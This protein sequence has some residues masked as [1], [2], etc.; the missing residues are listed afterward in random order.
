V[1]PESKFWKL[2]KEN[3]KDIH[4]TRFENWA[5]QGVPDCYGI[6]DGVSIWVELKV[7]TSNRIK[8]SPFQIAWNFSHSLKG[9]RNF[10]MA[11]TPSPSLLYIFPGS[12]VRSIGSIAKLP[13]PHW[14]INMVQG[15]QPWQQVQRILLHSP[16]PP[17]VKP[18]I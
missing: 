10:I 7:I 16:L 13:K 12:V 18:S 4:W 8:L 3:L 2:I 1:K 5:S 15:P 17:S 6:K 11:T 9:G 14:C